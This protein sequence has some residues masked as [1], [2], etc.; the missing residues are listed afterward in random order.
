ML[1]HSA[2]HC[3]GLLAT[4]EPTVTLRACTFA[5]CPV[6]LVKP[7]ACTKQLSAMQAPAFLTFALSK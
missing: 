3:S 5:L 2:Y 1:V 4:L 6:T 7:K